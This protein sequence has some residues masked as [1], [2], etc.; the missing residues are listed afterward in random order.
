MLLIVKVLL[1]RHG[2]SGGGLAIRGTAMK[3]AEDYC[4]LSFSASA[5]LVSVSG[6]LGK[7][8]PAPRLLS[9]VWCLILD[10]RYRI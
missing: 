7:T 8:L 6:G 1:K 4:R 10:L 2:R 3:K 5:L 9:A